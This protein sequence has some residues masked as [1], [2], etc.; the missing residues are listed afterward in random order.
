MSSPVFSSAFL[1]PSDP[2]LPMPIAFPVS[3]PAPPVMVTTQSP[4]GTALELYVPSWFR[5]ITTFSAPSLINVTCPTVSGSLSA[6]TVTLP[7]TFAVLLLQPISTAA[8]VTTTIPK[9]SQRAPHRCFVLMISSSH[10]VRGHNK[11]ARRTPVRLPVYAQRTPLVKGSRSFYR[12]EKT[13]SNPNTACF[14]RK[15]IVR[16]CSTLYIARLSY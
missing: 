1:P 4:T 2:M 9:A 11:D 13:R 14:L 8:P 7:L 3:S 6:P 5:L 12:I 16:Q 15:P 10:Q